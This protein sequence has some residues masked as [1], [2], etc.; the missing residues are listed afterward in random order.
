MTEPTTP[1]E[2]PA[3]SPGDALLVAR[4]RAAGCVFAED[5]ARILSGAAADPDSLADLV[6]RRVGGEPLEH[7]VGWVEFCGLRVGVGP[8]VFVPRQRTT[9][10]VDEAAHAITAMRRASPT[11]VTAVDLCCGAGAVSMALAARFSAGPTRLAVHAADIDP[12]AVACAAANLAGI[13]HVHQ[14]DLFDAVPDHLRG[15]VDVLT[16]NAPY[17]PTSAIAWMPPEARAHEP[18]VALDGGPDGLD[19]QRRVIAV[20]PEWISD[21]GVV[22][23]E[24]SRAQA[25]AGVAA[26]AAVGLTAVVISSDDVDGTVLVAR[27]PP[28]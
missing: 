16:A 28:P 3:N 10:V 25:A 5:E 23:V 6:R 4:L 21:R 22:L 9:L 8:G 1:L 2:T 24:T 17:V 20:A 27:R 13:G 7:I 11:P 18:R 15:H 19:V 26:F 12:R 14:G